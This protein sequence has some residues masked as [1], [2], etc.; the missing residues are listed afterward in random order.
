MKWDTRAARPYRLITTAGFPAA[1]QSAGTSFVT[2]DPAPITA[3]SPMV[4]PLRMML[5]APMKTSSPMA[6]GFVAQSSQPRGPRRVSASSAW[7]S[8]SAYLD[9]RLENDV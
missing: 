9:I 5:C 3:R 1:T 7:K 4:T 8:G 6:M 2:T